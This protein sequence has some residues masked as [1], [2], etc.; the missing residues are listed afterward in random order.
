MKT[1]RPACRVTLYKARS[2]TQILDGQQASKRLSG[3][4]SID[5]TPLLSDEGM[6]L[7]TSK[8][9][10]QPA[11][12]W[13]LELFDKP[14]ATTGETA[15]ALIEPMD[16]IE[17]RLARSPEQYVAAGSD[18]PVVMRGVVSRVSRSAVMA[19]GRPSRRV[20]VSGQDFGKFLQMIQIFY[21]TGSQLGQNIAS[22]WKWAL[23]YSDASSTKIKPAADFVSDVLSQVVDPYLMSIDQL[24]SPVGMGATRLMSI[25]PDVSIAGLVDPLILQSYQGSI[26]DLLRMA[27]DVGPFNEL[28]VE[29]GSSGVS[30]VV[31]PIPYGPKGNV[32]APPYAVDP[33]AIKELSVERSDAG[34]ANLYWVDNDRWLSF[35]QN[36]MK[37]AAGSGPANTYQQYDAYNSLLSMFGLR[38]M[39]VPTNMAPLGL[40]APDSYNDSAFGSDAKTMSGWLTGRR[41]D[42]IAQNKDNVVYECGRMRLRGDEKLRAGTFLTVGAGDQK[43][44][45]YAVQVDHEFAPFNSFFSTVHFVRGS[46]WINRSASSE[47]WYWREL[48][49]SGVK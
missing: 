18:M 12:G 46:G 9:V 47:S 45:C 17:I 3:V 4:S 11:G 22:S 33:T 26:G 40:L 21:I 23:Q 29:D 10:N 24:A 6:A 42:L 30:L 19:D 38:K 41:L 25:A 31:R 5:L 48:D 2:R 36:T 28:F 32:T 43:W 7:N 27:C 35:F 1:Y 39:E 16:L 20:S 49:V 14:D 8:S 34:V 37:M 13:S 15:Y 44:E